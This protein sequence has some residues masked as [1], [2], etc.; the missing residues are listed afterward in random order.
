MLE[1]A[2]NEG[3]RSR[4]INTYYRACILHDES[5]WQFTE[6]SNSRDLNPDSELALSV[7]TVRKMSSDT[8]AGYSHQAPRI[9]L[10]QAM[11]TVAI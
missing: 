4:M 2:Y 9:L 5:W 7:R 6:K 3:D 10:F 8:T 11:L 1:V